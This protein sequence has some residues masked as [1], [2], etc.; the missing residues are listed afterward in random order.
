MCKDFLMPTFLLGLMLMLSGGVSAQPVAG[1]PRAGQVPSIIEIPVRISLDRLYE[2][3]EREMPLQA[4]NWRGWRKAYGVNT[5]YRAWRGALQFTMQ[6]DIL[7]VQAHVRYWIR[8][9]KQ[10]LG[11][12]DLESDCGVDEPPRQAIIGVQIRL[13]WGPDWMLRPVFRVMP[14]RFLDGCEMTIADIDVTPLIEKEFQQQLEDRMRAALAVLA[15]RLHAIRQQAEQD[16]S[17]L[18][19]PVQLWAEQWLLLNPRSVAL[20]PL[21]GY[22]NTLSAKLAVLMAPEVLTGS[23]PVPGLRPLPPLE[24]FYPRSSGLNLQLSVV[25]DYADLGRVMTELLADESIDIGG[26][27]ARIAA[28][29]LAGQG[30]EI[31]VNAK[32]SGPA[33]GEVALKAD[34]VF[35][36]ETQQFGLENL[37]YTYKAEDPL[38]EGEAEF[39]RGYIRKLLMSAA[40]QQLQQRMN[41]WKGNLQAL[42]DRITPADMKLDMASLQLRQVD[43]DMTTESVRL[44]GLASGRIVLEFQ[45][46]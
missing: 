9:H 21:T 14:T 12:I 7:M 37:D 41:Q 44:N 31:R 35:T 17:L 2:M 4:G 33:A 3:A 36:P 8:A 30:K 39:L 25:L 1:Q 28:I 23:R 20:S 16:W 45:K 26:H 6:G 22:G 13:D 42:F 24:R 15:P 19:E 32:L 40:N 5:Q 43:I 10:V 11:T 38:L 34:L 46:E 29:E 27:Q 18:Q